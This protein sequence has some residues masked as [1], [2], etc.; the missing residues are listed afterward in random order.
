[1]HIEY[2]LVND[3]NKNNSRPDNKAKSKLKNEKFPGNKNTVK[4]L[5]CIIHPQ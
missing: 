3:Q 2:F 1:M 5:S 4:S